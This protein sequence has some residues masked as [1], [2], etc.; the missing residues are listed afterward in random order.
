MIT[1]RPWLLQDLQVSPMSKPN[2]QPVLLQVSN[3]HLSYSVQVN[4]CDVSAQHSSVRLTCI[5]KNFF[6]H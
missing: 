4:L 2:L 6:L 5:V 1:R 3:F